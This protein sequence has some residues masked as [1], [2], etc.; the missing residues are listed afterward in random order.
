MYDLVIWDF[1]GTIADDIVIGIEA[2]NVVLSSRGMKT[3][4]VMRP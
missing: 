4:G 1:N 2:A 3:I